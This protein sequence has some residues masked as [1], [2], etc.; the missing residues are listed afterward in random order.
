MKKSA[1]TM[2]LLSSLPLLLAG[3]ASTDANHS[4]P[5]VEA[6]RPPALAVPVNSPAH[7]P[8]AAPVTPTPVAPARN[9]AVSS[10]T[11]VASGAPVRN[12]APAASGKSDNSTASN[13]G[14][15]AIAGAAAGCA[16][17]KLVGEK[18]ADG[19]AIGAVLGAV[20]GWSISSEKTGSAQA[21]NTAA[22]QAGLPVPANEIR[23][24]QY[25]LTPS[26]SQVQAGGAPLQVVGDITLYGNS[27]RKPDVRQSMLLY[28]ANGEATSDTPQIARL[29]KVDGA[30]RYRATGVYKIPRGMAPGPYL[31]Q[32]ELL[33]NGK[34]VAQRT[35]GFQ[36][37]APARPH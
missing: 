37:S 30:G 29:E 28:Q 22:K 31:V 20:L 27:A 21:A 16:L 23:L 26:A 9:P 12:T 33:I 7:N 8:S 4:A 6:P 2:L 36:V 15:G 13:V 17:A 35:A 32:S 24:Q 18:C 25:T 34:R 14:T 19:A 10:V 11:T 3:C 5:V 1:I